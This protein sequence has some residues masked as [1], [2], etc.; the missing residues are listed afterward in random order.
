MHI[1][2]S[3]FGINLSLNILRFPVRKIVAY[4]SL[5]VM[6]E[7][8]YVT[9]ASQINI[10]IFESLLVC[11]GVYHCFCNVCACARV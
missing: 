2:G 5:L 11:C 6:Y 3:V 9:S 8:F 10:I 4:Y 7:S 1:G